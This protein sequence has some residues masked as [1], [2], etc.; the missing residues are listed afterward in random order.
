MLIPKQ[1]KMIDGQEFV[2]VS[3]VPGGR[4]FY[5]LASSLKKEQKF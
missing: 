1:A 2:A 5:M 4:V 3:K